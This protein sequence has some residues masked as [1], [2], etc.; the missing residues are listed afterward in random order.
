MCLY[1]IIHLREDIFIKAKITKNFD[2][3]STIEH[4]QHEG[5]SLTYFIF[6]GLINLVPLCVWGIDFLYTIWSEQMLNNNN[7]MFNSRISNSISRDNR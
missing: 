3:T 4:F 7:H 5:Y 1:A 2:N 6:L